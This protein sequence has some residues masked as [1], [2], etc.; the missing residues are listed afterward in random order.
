MFAGLPWDEIVD[1]AALAEEPCCAVDDG[2]PEPRDRVGVLTADQAAS[3]VDSESVGNADEE[4]TGDGDNED[5]GPHA[6]GNLWWL[7][8]AFCC[9][10]FGR[11]DPGTIYMYAL[12][13]ATILCTATAGEMIE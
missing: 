11:I 6:A 5:G 9:T 7:L 4:K 10:T 2:L 13:G 1:G 8:S 12:M 3:T